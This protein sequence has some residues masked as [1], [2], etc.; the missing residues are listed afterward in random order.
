MAYTG[1]KGVLNLRRYQQIPL[2]VPDSAYSGG[3][4]TAPDSTWVTGERLTAI[5]TDGS[6][7]QNTSGFA[8]I[9]ELNRIRLHST[10]EG[11]LNDSPGTRINITTKEAGT[12]FIL[13][14]E[15]NSPQL[16]TLATFLNLNPTA[17]VAVGY[18]GTTIYRLNHIPSVY[19]AF[20]DAETLPIWELQ[21][22]LEKWVLELSAPA[23]EQNRL[24][25]TFSR[26]TKSVITGSGSINFIFDY[27]LAPI[28]SSIAPALQLMFMTE[29]YSQ[30]DAKFYIKGN[31][32]GG[33][34][35]A[36]GISYMTC[37]IYISSS[38]ILTNLAIDMSSDQI[39][40]GTSSFTVTGPIR[41][42]AERLFT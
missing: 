14:N 32:E 36:T 1:N 28:R 10:P 34:C 35:A 22:S 2:F 38:I 3:V 37:P 27:S 33:F 5:F 13:T 19:K 30:A 26:S 11:A 24:G 15:P 20:K 6:A 12:S 21:G 4:F 8:A 23:V 18:A 42:R 40:K 16:S 41:K 7:M 31:T 29:E 25:E 39:A 9:D 17:P